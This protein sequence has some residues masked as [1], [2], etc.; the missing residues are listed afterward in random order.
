[1]IFIMSKLFF[2]GTFLGKCHDFLKEPVQWCRKG[3]DQ[4]LKVLHKNPETSYDEEGFSDIY[5]AAMVLTS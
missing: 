2:L 4:E 5:N 3:M 1:M